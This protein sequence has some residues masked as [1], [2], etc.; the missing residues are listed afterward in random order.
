[1]KIEE[2]QENEFQQE[3]DDWIDEALRRGEGFQS[4][5]DRKMYI[6][7]LGDP[8]KHPMFSTNIDDLRNN[9]MADAFRLLREEDKTNIELAIMYKDEGNEFCK[10]STVKEKNEAYD[11]YSYALTFIDKDDQ[12]P[13]SSS[14]NS[15]ESKKLRS[16]ILSNRSF[17]SLSIKNY[18][19][20]IVDAIAALYY[21]PDNIKAYYRQAK[22]LHDLKKYNDSYQVCNNGLL[23]DKNNK[24]LLQLLS[25]NQQQLQIL[26]NKLT[27]ETKHKNQLHCRW[28]SMWNLMMENNL[29]VGYPLNPIKPVNVLNQ[30]LF[31]HIDSES[32]SLHFPI[33]FLYPQYGQFD[34]LESVDSSDMIVYQIAA[35]FPEVDDISDVDSMTPWDLKHEYHVSSLVA[36]LPLNSCPKINTL[37]EWKNCFEQLYNL[38]TANR[39][40]SSDYDDLMQKYNEYLID[41]EKKLLYSDKATILEI[42]LG[43]TIDM[44]SKIPGHILIGGMINILIFPKDSMAHK[45]YLQTQKKLQI[46]VK[47]IFP[48][49][50]IV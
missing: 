34:I 46:D 16:Q 49:G 11:K 8:L 5:E 9:P 25:L 28:E 35:I 19:Y 29:S 37:E 20:C 31:P 23:V 27:R 3:L 26:E 12:D 6:E 4:D 44:I 36:Y 30:F 13:S 45:S 38:E 1:M 22:A 2:E 48:D 15:I 24:E 39:S 14:S 47:Q 43:C 17:V 50:R 32:N 33:V 41:Y 18:R 10:K 7:S 21:W 42:H 40:H